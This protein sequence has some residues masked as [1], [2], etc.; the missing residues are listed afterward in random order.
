ASRSIYLPSICSILPS[1]RFG[2]VQASTLPLRQASAL[3]EIAPGD[4]KYTKLLL[5]TR[6][7]CRYA[8]DPRSASSK[9]PPPAS[10]SVLACRNCTR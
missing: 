2:I 5:A 1:T 8:Y 7:A 4:R 9:R 3:A 6:E 10:A